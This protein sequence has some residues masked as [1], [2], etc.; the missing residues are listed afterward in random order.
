MSTESR[1]P[2]PD[3]L[4]A[5]VIAEE[6]SAR[7]GHL[8]IFLGYA[9]GVGKTYAMLEAAHQRKREGLD[10][11]IGY[12]ETHNRVESERLVADLET[13]PRKT[14]E[15][16]NVTLTEMDVDVIL[17]RHPALVLVDELAHT[18]APGS[19]HPKRYLDVE[20][21]LNAGIDVYTTL[22]IQH[23]ES[24]NDVVAQI[25][26][27]LV[28]E[29]IP[30]RVI[31]E[32]SE[33]ELVDLPPDELLNRLREGKVYVP[34]QAGRALQ[35]FFRQGNLTALREMTMRRAAARVDNQM[36]S[37]METRAIA[38]PWAA[39][40]RLMVCISP[41]PLGEHLIRSARRLADELNAE[42]MAVYVETP[43]D[44]TLPQQKR[45]MV[46]GTMR[47]AEELGAR[48][49]T[50]LSSGSMN[51]LAQTLV[52]FAHKN[53]VTKIVAG[54][55]LRPAWYERLRGSLVS[56]LIHMSGNIDIYVVPTSEPAHLP[57]E[58]NPLQIH[59]N[60]P[61]YIW[62]ILLVA[63]ATGLSYFFAQDISPT[64]L[65]MIYLLAVVITAVYLGRGPAI[66]ASLLGVLAF[67]FFFV[68]PRF[69][70]SVSD[71]EYLLTFTG[72][73]LVGIVI[74]ALTVQARQ[75][76]EAAQRREADTA[77]LYALS[78]DLA[79]ADGL[80]AVINA[81]RTHI[82]ADFGRD[83]I[84]FLPE[85]SSN[86]RAYSDDPAAPADETEV[87]LAIWV[88]QHGEP[89]GRGTD[90]LP[91]A[92]ARYIPLKTSQRVIGV[93]C[94]KPPDEGQKLTPEQ[95]RL[96]DAIAS[97]AA[98]AIE[99]VN[100]ADQARQIKLLQAAEKLQNALLN[101]I[102]HDLRTPLV[103]ITGALTT[104]EEQG[105][106]L[107]TTAHRSLVET[108]REEADRLN[109]LVGNLLDMTRLEAGA[110]KVK[111]E[112]CDVED[113]IGTA[114]GQMDERL[115]GRNIQIIVPRKFPPIAV[116]F[117]LIVHVIHNLLDNALKY[118]PAGSPLEVRA[119]VHAD[120]VYIE[121][122]DR[123]V[124]IPEGD[125]ER[126]FDKFYRV[127]HPQQVT[128]TGLGLAICKGIVE[129]HGGRIW[130]E[131]RPGGG[132]CFTIALPISE[133]K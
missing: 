85:G 106:S 44:S 13:L 94:I 47:L 56:H 82:E 64:N 75:Q 99:R 79:A 19:R 34:D 108:A 107:D 114:V 51:A 36:R 97:Q 10:V 14:I 18:N 67:D 123:G 25:T 11:V 31:D 9:A 68:P 23:L 110:L 120:E 101:S 119:E 109:R 130:A 28:H 27:V 60:L 15:Y 1:R 24:L 33:L 8:K 2:D 90:T 96:V 70:F 52:D 3:Q 76:A 127:Q 98:Q 46:A 20:E 41:N 42:W 100:L 83:V 131:N 62:S 38:G 65:V 21:L 84:V 45:D 43:R 50:L 105:E 128:G 48:S 16:H 124:G 22:N 78:R 39:A 133:G 61:R 69:T 59:S 30:D 132:S 77:V 35:D 95:R 37:Y 117:V 116:D 66:L 57:P 118:S 71:T 81:I 17:N 129:A 53:N 26:G 104:L 32:A 87:S 89:A 63:T 54:K 102:S 93:L 86:L 72:L 115:M 55:P 73:F 91:A 58:E 88:Y 103:S 7:R 6:A 4:L 111:S 126:I 125:L 29:T 5:H 113:V 122:L 112:S 121:V 12:I 49:Y 80:S 40:E 74:S 92:K